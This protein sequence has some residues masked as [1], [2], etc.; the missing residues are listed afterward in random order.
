MIL[1]LIL[2]NRCFRQDDLQMKLNW[3]RVIFHQS[4]VQFFNVHAQHLLNSRVLFRTN[5]VNK[6][7]NH[8]SHSVKTDRKTRSTFQFTF[9][10]YFTITKQCKFRFE[11]PEELVEFNAGVQ[12]E[13][14]LDLEKIA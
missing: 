10:Q 9:A 5:F 12:R 14:S 4:N 11:L 3:S 8:Q 1:T 6:T 2:F 13:Q 7:S